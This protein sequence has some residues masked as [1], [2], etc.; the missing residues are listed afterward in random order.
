[1]RGAGK[2]ELGSSGWGFFDDVGGG[3]VGGKKNERK[4]ESVAPYIL[5]DVVDGLL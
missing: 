3:T 1:V 2:R 5:G 4:R